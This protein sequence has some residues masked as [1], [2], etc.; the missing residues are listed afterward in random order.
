LSAVKTRLGIL[1]SLG[2]AACDEPTVV[3][4]AGETQP[5]DSFLLEAPA[6]DTDGVLRVLVLHDMEGLSGQSDPQTFD[7]DH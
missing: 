7:F 5:A 4:T 3:E 6:P 1:F 2:L